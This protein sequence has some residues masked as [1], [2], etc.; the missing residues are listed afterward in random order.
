MPTKVILKISKGKRAGEEL[1][2]YDQKETLILGRLDDCAIVLPDATVSRYHCLLDVAPPSVVVRD[3]GSLNGTY[4]NEE[5]IGQRRVDLSAEEARKQTYDEFPMKTGD[6]LRLGPDCEITLNI[7]IP[8]YCTECLCEIEQPGY[9]NGDNL[10]VC[11]ACHAKALEQKAKKEADE[12]LAREMEQQRIEAEKRAKELAAKAKAAADE[13]ARKK[14]EKERLEAEKRAKEL[15]E[16]EKLE[17][18]RRAEEEEERR[19]EAARI[20]EEKA[21]RNNRR[22]EVCGGPLNGELNICSTCLKDPVRILEFL[23]LEADNGND[24]VKGIAGYHKIKELGHGGMGVV[25]LVEEKKTGEQMALKLMLPEAA[26]DK[27]NRQLFLREAHVAGQLKHTNV[28]RQFNSGQSGDTYFILMELCRG[29]S[30]D[31]LMAKNGGKLSLDLATHITLQILDGL[32]Y[33]HAARVV[34]ELA[35][36]TSRTVRGIVHRDFKPGNIFLSDNSSRPVAKVA[37]FGLAKAFETAGLSGHTR[38]G[39]VAGTL[40]F[41]PRQQILNFRYAKPDVDVWAAA[42]SYYNMLTGT[43]PKYLGGKDPYIAA[44]NEPAVP[45]RQRNPSIPEKLAKVIDTAL[46]DRPEIGVR[47]AKELKTAIENAL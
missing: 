23:L 15:A 46:I 1:P 9:V 11:H 27:K 45:I 40:P 10:P 43:Y 41:M 28:V 25:W 32:I 36:G 5:K 4:L 7:V 21:K 34:S 37:D 38:S 8:Q 19:K 30:V 26:A 47:S 3:F 18:R 17:A 39:V 20:A 2:P 22:C 44:L 29:G 31:S 33:T 6:R 14:A 24:E 35:D 16:K 13:R 12:R 42:A